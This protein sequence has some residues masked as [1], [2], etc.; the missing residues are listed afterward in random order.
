MRR[1]RALLAI[2][3]ATALQVAVPVAAPARAASSTLDVNPRVGAPGSTITVSGTCSGT[4]RVVVEGRPGGWYDVPPVYADVSA[5]PPN[6]PFSFT[7][8]M[9]VLPSTVRLICTVDGLTEF[10][11]LLISPATG[12]LA[13][14]FATAADGGYLVTIPGVVS[15]ELLAAFGSTGDPVPL[16][17]VATSPAVTVRLE[18][19]AGVTDV[20]I[21]GMQDL[22]ENADARQV[23]RVQG[24]AVNLPGAIATTTT[25]STMTTATVVD[26][27]STVPGGPVAPDDPA[28]STLPTPTADAA[29]AVIPATGFSSRSPAVAA[30]TCIL[31]GLLSVALTRA[32]PRTSH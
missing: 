22:G 12:D 20:V 3:I 27:P 16:S 2:A 4:P 32:R 11:Q 13:T 24:W 26:E 23:V 8:S 30:G 31:L 28:P 9:P 6:G 15:P 21:V 18:P 10:V 5:L 19:A 14:G 1:Q 7:T 25:S 17:I 29:S